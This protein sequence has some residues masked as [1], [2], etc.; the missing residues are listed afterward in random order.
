MSED[1]RFNQSTGEFESRT[2]SK[3][4]NNG[5]GGQAYY[6]E[7]RLKDNLRIAVN[8]VTQTKIYSLS[9]ALF[10]FSKKF[11]IT[12]TVGGFLNSQ[13]LF[14][15]LLSIVFVPVSLTLDIT[16]STL[17]LSIGSILLLLIFTVL[18]FIIIYYIIYSIVKK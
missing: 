9:N 1:Y 13:G 10:V 6:F 12:R 4:G 5:K 15:K 7:R 3:R 17:G 14:G 8:K 2:S 16:V 18:V 11:T